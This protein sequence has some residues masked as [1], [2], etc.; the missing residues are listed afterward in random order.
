MKQ[1]IKL[2]LTVIALFVSAKTFSQQTVST[3]QFRRE[4]LTYINRVRARGCNCGVTY[5]PPA[6]PLIWNDQLEVAAIEHAADMSMRGYFSHES[7]DGRSFQDRIMNTGYTIKGFKGIEVGEN[8]AFGPQTVAEVMEGWLHSP[9]HCRNL[10]NPGFKEI[11]IAETNTYWVQD[12]G[13]RKPFT[14]EEQQM[15]KSGRYRIIQRY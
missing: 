5:M 15:I 6:P 12:F 13:G 1:S 9:G 14:A 8:I 11:G 7:L 3:P 10:M 2:V 4:F